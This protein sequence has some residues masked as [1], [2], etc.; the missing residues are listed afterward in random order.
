[1]IFDEVRQKYVGSFFMAHGV[2]NN[3]TQE[4]SFSTTSQKGIVLNNFQ[5]NGPEIN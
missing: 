1:L 3:E 4:T 5:S 2:I